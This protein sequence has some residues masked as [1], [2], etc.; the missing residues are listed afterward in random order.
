MFRAGRTKEEV[1]AYLATT[2][3]SASAKSQKIKLAEDIVQAGTNASSKFSSG[4]KYKSC[5]RALQYLFCK[6]E[7]YGDNFYQFLL[8]LK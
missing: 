3:L 5:T 8:L 7:G 4:L 1:K 6:T 2:S